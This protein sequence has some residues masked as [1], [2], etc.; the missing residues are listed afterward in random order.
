MHFPSALQVLLDDPISSHKQAI[1]RQIMF[2]GW[3]TYL[4]IGKILK[5]TTIDTNTILA[6]RTINSIS[7][8]V[9]YLARFTTITSESKFA[10]VASVAIWR[11]T[12]IASTI[13]V[14]NASVVST[15]YSQ[16]K[17]ISLIRNL[18]L[19]VN[20]KHVSESW[21]HVSYSWKNH[22]RLH[23]APSPIFKFMF[24]KLSL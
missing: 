17:W 22:L 15:I 5:H 20:C 23:L 18:S 24:G 4:H 7:H 3:I 13:D 19:K 6:Y 21:M 16:R 2:H 9:T 14:T 8:I 10:W 11:G 1:R 12:I